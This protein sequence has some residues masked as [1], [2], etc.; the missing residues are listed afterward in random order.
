MIM[1]NEKKIEAMKFLAE[2]NPD[3][4]KLIT[5]KRCDA[6][7]HVLYD[8]KKNWSPIKSVKILGEKNETDTN[9]RLSLK[10]KI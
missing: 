2:M 3:R 5:Y 10:D 4:Y 6:I 8:I 9:S 1:I 7:R